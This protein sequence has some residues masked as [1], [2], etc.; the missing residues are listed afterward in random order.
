MNELRIEPG[1]SKDLGPCDCCRGNSRTV[2]GYVYDSGG[3][4]AAYF[5]QWTLGHVDRHG[6]QFDLIIG[7]W[8]DEAQRSDRCSISL[9][10]RRTDQGPSFMVIDSADRPIASSD[11]VGESLARADVIGTPA[12]R[13]RIQDR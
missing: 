1:G 3:A 7:E 5:V 12:R 2:W 4:T 9:E 13:G 8:G 10:F 11:L 6:A